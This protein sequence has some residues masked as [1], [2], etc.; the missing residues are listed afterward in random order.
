MIVALLM[1]GLGSA[2]IAA[3]S[4]RYD[5]MP[6]GAARASGGNR[7]SRRPKPTA[8]CCG[9]A[10]APVQSTRRTKNTW[11]PFGGM[12]FK[13]RTSKCKRHDGRADDG[14]ERNANR[15]ACGSYNSAKHGAR[16]THSLLAAMSV[17]EGAHLLC[18]RNLPSDWPVK[19]LT[20]R[21]CD[22]ARL[23]GHPPGQIWLVYGGDAHVTAS[24][25]QSATCAPWPRYAF[26]V[27]KIEICLFCTVLSV[28]V[29]VSLQSAP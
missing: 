1:S 10:Q 25:L 11:A 19:N 23:E 20:H 28:C 17:P 27:H 14:T 21:P 3:G 9:R 22:V 2:N 29:S 26:L 13:R 5:A 6:R 7:F 12:I 16:S 15:H 4:N 18:V 8:R 24:A